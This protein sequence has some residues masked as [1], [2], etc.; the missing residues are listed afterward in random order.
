MRVNLHQ[1]YSTQPTRVNASSTS[2]KYVSL[3]GIGSLRSVFVVR[4]RSEFSIK[5]SRTRAR[6][7]ACLS[8]S[9]RACKGSLANSL[10]LIR[11]WQAKLQQQCALQWVK[12]VVGNQVNQS[13]G[14]IFLNCY[15][16]EVVDSQRW[17]EL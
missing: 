13:S 12:V 17:V 9:C 3:T 4:V 11:P 2:E 5:F 10:M 1:A 7:F 15:T 16:L 8:N 14:L 6:R